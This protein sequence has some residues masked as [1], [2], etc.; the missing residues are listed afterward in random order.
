[1]AQGYEGDVTVQE[2]WTALSD[3]PAAVLVDVRTTAE[4]TYVG[5]PD[6]SSLGR[7]PVLAEWQSFPSMSVDPQF[8]Q[9]V[10]AAVADQP[11]DRQ[12]R[13]Y[14]LCRS[15]ARSVAAAR[16]LTAAGFE[17]CFN[18]LDGFEGGPDA[19]GHRGTRSGWKAEGLPW[20]Q[21]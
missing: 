19:D 1:M 21:R 18:V 5:I 6:L 9:R 13:V 2:C 12:R 14:L 3:D 8:V 7:A 15:G 16:A 10:T 17:H 11:E 4:W 20:S